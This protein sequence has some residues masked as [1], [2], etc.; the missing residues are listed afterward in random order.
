MDWDYEAFLR[1]HAGAAE[2]VARLQGR[3]TRVGEAVDEDQVDLIASREDVRA[4]L[5]R[6]GYRER[7]EEAVD[8][9]SAG[10]GEARS[11]MVVYSPDKLCPACPELFNST[12]HEQGGHGRGWRA[13]LAQVRAGL[14]RDQFFFMLGR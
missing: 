7:E 11:W 9:S 2:R 13:D 10:Q 3:G 4:L 6:E 1:R 8:S 14:P 5:L 12:A